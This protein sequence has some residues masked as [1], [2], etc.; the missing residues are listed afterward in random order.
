MWVI[1][2]AA[3]IMVLLALLVTVFNQKEM[4]REK[5]TAAQIENA[6]LEAS[7]NE[8][9][10]S[11]KERI[12]IINESK[13]K[14]E[15][16]F[17]GISAQAL[18]K[19]EEKSYVEEE[20][21]GR[22]L[23]D[24]MKPMK[25]SLLK[26]DDKMNALEKDRKGDKETLTEQLRRVAESEKDLL[27]ETK[28]LKD[29]LS[30]PE[31]RGMWGEMQLKR[32]IEVSGMINH[33]DFLE[34]SVEETENGRIRP[35]MIIKLAG[36]RTIIVDSKAPIEGFLK[37][38]SVDSESEKKV[39]LERHARHLKTHIQMLSKK[40]YYEG[41]AETPEFVVLFIPSEAFL[42]SALQ[43]DPTLI[44]VAARL[45]VILAT[46]TTLIGLL[47]SISY[48]WKTENLTQNARAIQSLGCELYKRLLDM[49]KHLSAMGK[50]LSS[51]VDGYNKTIGT[52]ERRVLSSARKFEELGAAST[53]LIPT[54]F[55]LIDAELRAPGIQHTIEVNEIT[56]DE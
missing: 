27:K 17:K 48:G 20:R 54:T 9:N 47:R 40:K 50:S 2:F 23:S 31:I 26:L 39:E 49:S 15:E 16:V 42:S 13:E 22:A 56:I 1:L 37:A 33:C 41:V 11:F 45:N 10:K 7:I 25:E 55:E 52:Y 28:G 29:A 12:E 24:L 43:M 53:E 14:L 32:T 34:Q 51:A 8:Q 35:D 36:N 21:R 6:K 18:Q 4:I 3:V 44:E 19:M 30:K 5:L 38:L 46:P